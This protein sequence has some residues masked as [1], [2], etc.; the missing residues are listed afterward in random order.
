MY[1]NGNVYN[2]SKYCYTLS[3]NHIKITFLKIKCS[4]INNNSTYNKTISNIIF[5][6]NFRHMIVWCIIQI[7]CKFL[8][9]CNQPE[10]N[11]CQRL[12]KL[13]KLLQDK[14]IV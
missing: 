11:L 8:I 12:I 9:S 5:N 7:L 4:C 2:Y 10:N 14:D 13:L 3:I 6:N 1:A